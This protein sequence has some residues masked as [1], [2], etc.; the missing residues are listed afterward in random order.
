[1]LSTRFC[2]SFNVD[3]GVTPNISRNSQSRETFRKQNRGKNPNFVSQL[4]EEKL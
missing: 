3:L 2:P 1:M 4:N